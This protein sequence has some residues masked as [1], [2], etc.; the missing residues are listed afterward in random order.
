MNDD[1]KVALEILAKIKDSDL[2]EDTKSV[3]KPADILLQ[4]AILAYNGNQSKDNFIELIRRAK[5]FFGAEHKYPWKRLHE[6]ANEVIK[7]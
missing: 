4:N 2:A 3:N 7:E 6:I 5:H 1:T